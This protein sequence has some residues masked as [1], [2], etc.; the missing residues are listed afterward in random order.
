MADGEY[1]DDHTVRSI[2]KSVLFFAASSP[3]AEVPP[4]P[5]Q[6][7]HKWRSDILEKIREFEDS[8]NPKVRDFIDRIDDW[9]VI[10]PL[11]TELSDTKDLKQERQAL[12]ITLIQRHFPAVTE[13]DLKSLLILAQLIEHGTR[14]RRIE[15]TLFAS[16]VGRSSVFEWAMLPSQFRDPIDARLSEAEDPTKRLSNKRVRINDKLHKPEK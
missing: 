2:G 6:T 8:A 1:Y 10:P 9:L 3:W 15:Q 11:T 16:N 4:D 13:F 5:K 7:F 12:I 14:V